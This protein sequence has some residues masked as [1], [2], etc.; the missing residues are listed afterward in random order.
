VV[1]NAS[2]MAGGVLGLAGER[3]TKVDTA[4]LRM[5]SDHNLMMIVG[6]W[7]LRPGIGYQALCD[8]VK[9]TLLKYPRFRQRV[10]EDAGGATWVEDTTFD[11]HRHVVRE[12]LP[13]GRKVTRSRRCR[14]ASANWP[15]SRWTAS[16]R[17]GSS[18]WS[19]TTR[20]AAR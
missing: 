14:P 11:I 6:V 13:R 4:W 20:A 10:V 12:T 15:W 8:R 19:R 18:T 3:M 2:R 17:C 9:G 7:T 1:K 5:D 16:G